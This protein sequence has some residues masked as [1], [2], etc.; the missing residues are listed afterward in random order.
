[1]LLLLLACPDVRD[2]YQPS[3]GDTADTGNDPVE[4][5]EHCGTISSDTTWR[6]DRQHLV[7]CDVVVE[8]GTLTIE[9]GVTVLFDERT[10]LQVATE[11]YAAGLQVSGESGGVTLSASSSAGW[12]G[13]EIGELATS[14]RL[15][16]LV[17]RDATGG[18]VIE[19]AEVTVVGLGIDG[20]SDAGLTLSGGARLAEGA[21]GVTVTHAGGYAVVA[22]VAT[23]HTLPAVASA[24]T[25]NG[26]DAVYLSGDEITTSVEWEDLGVPYVL[27]ETVDVGGSAGEPAVFTVAEG[28]ELRF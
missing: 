24:Y 18:V 26:T 11:G 19:G 2:V 6:A 1:M 27:A 23:A 5:E 21:E 13:V 15:A 10:G 22:D 4:T 28:T 3:A 7:T 8:R 12:S 9:G 25:G 20:T 16:G 17:V 14:V